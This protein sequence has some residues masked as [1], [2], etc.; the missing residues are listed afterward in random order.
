M[1][2]IIK[3]PSIL[4]Y[5]ALESPFANSS[6]ALDPEV[7]TKPQL[8]NAVE[9]DK[10]AVENTLQ[11]QPLNDELSFQLQQKNAEQLAKLEEQVRS[12]GFKQGYIEGLAI[13]KEELAETLRA[14]ESLPEKGKLALEEQLDSH[15]ALIA[16][17]VF[18]AVCKIIGERLVTV[19][20]C[21]EL[22]SHLIRGVLEEDL[23]AV[24]VSPR[25]LARIQKAGLEASP[26]FSDFK[27][28]ADS[29]VELGG[30]I[31]KL[32]DGVI[33]GRIET[34]FGIFA[35]T[36]KDVVNSDGIH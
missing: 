16:S 10:S 23:V 1:G 36:L 9:S 6:P 13:A 22:V 28:E 26:P 25:D 24:K 2:S 12:D 30:C 11:T 21:K 34:Q 29:S 17:I 20:G 19:D 15:H 35:D 31:I 3:S 18:E 4:E 32:R 8:Q 27:L 33:D 7:A 14:L 5:H